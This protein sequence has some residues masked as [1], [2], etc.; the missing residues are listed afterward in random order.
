MQKS[1]SSLSTEELSRSRRRTVDNSPHIFDDFIGDV[2]FPLEDF[3]SDTKTST[4]HFVDR[5]RRDE[6][7]PRPCV[8]FESSKVLRWI[9]AESCANFVTF[10]CAFHVIKL[11]L[12]EIAFFQSNFVIN[13]YTTTFLLSLLLVAESNCSGIARKY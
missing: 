10:C 6:K 3:Y 9:L 1:L 13:F 7:L 11:P 5:E 4:K 8:Y 2:C 12:H